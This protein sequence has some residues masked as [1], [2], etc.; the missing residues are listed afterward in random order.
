MET[1]KMTV[2][3]FRSYCMRQWI[4]DCIS[5]DLKGF[6]F[7]CILFIGA[8]QANAQY[9][10][11]ERKGCIVAQGNLA[12]GY[13]IESK[14]VS[15]YVNGDAELFLTDRFAY[16]GALWYSFATTHPGEPGIKANDAL[17]AGGEYHF[18][19]PK[20]IDPFVSL[21]PGVGLV[22][23]AYRSADGISLTPYTAAPLVSMSIGANYYVG[24]IFHFFFKVQGVVGQTFSVL[25]TPQRIDEIKF[26]CGLG[27]NTRVWKPRRRDKWKEGMM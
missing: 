10:W 21:T 12:P 9:V 11:D 23:V 25:P 5:T 18:L 1:Q 19:Q 14:Q 8:T 13:L 22:Q 4:K 24:W 2:K 15:A 26:T 3:P 7:T 27:L 6:L 17:F 16:E 20:R